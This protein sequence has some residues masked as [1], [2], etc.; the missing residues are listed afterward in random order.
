MPGRFPRRGWLSTTAANALGVVDER[1]QVE[2][3][4]RADVGLKRAA[5]LR[6]GA[7]VIRR[8]SGG[9]AI[10]WDDQVVAAHVGILG[11]EQDAAVGEKAGEDQRPG[12]EVLEQQLQRG[13]KESRVFRLQREVVG[14]LRAAAVSRPRVPD[15]V[16]SRRPRS[17]S[18]NATVRSCRSRTPW[19]SRGDPRAASARVCSA[20]SAAPRRARP[21]LPGRRNR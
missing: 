15:S 6:Q 4:R 1:L 8:A 2:L 9:D 12:A 10:R 13:G 20:P 21:R 7:S 11:R 19:G 3:R 14:R 18:P 5:Q 17:E 16:D